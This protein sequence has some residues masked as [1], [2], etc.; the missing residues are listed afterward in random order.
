MAG[1]PTGSLIMSIPKPNAH[2]YQDWNF[3]VQ[4]MM[5][6]VSCY[7]VVTGTE[8]H[9]TTCNRQECWDLQAENAL[10]LIG[11]SIELNQYEYI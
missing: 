3:A 11:L 7:G 5:H 4:M 9:L 8:E 6:R 2:Y 1:D 10:A